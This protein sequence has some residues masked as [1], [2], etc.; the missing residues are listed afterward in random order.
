MKKFVMAVSCLLVV[1]V[2]F[3]FG[4]PHYREW[5]ERRFMRE[6]HEFLAKGDYRN[7]TLCARQALDLK[8]TDLAA[9]RIMA[10]V[11][12]KLRSPAALTWR[13]RIL[14]L[15]PNNADNRLDLARSALLLGDFNRA[16]QALASIPKP[17]QNTAVFHKLAAMVSVTENNIAEADWH[18]TEAAKLDP[19]DKSLQL[20]QAVI[21]LQA[22]NRAV[23]EAAVKTLERLSDDPGLRKDALRHLAMAAV[24][25]NDFAA[26]ETFSKEL[27][28]DPKA[29]FEDRILHLSVLQAAGRLEFADYLASVKTE[30][31]SAPEKI[32]IVSGWMTSHQLVGDALRINSWATPSLGS[33]DW[34]RKSN[35]NFPSEWLSP[36]P[37]PTAVI[38]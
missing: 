8:A 10:D 33:R 25:N 24:R 11:S 15:E 28:T 16:G 2:G 20:N 38:G 27:Q 31:E 36:T 26:A 14:E 17:Q 9:T 37:M 23:V 35:P 19:E 29:N 32:P 3:Y 13:Q 34:M 30:A 22:R 6:A 7:A 12:E 21:H 18:F 1:G 5:K 4:R